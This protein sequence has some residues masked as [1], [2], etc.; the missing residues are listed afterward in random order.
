MKIPQVDLTRH[1]AEVH[2]EVIKAVDEIFRSQRFVL[3]ETVKNF[4]TAVAEYCQTKYAIGVASGTDALTLSLM[5]LGVK[6][7]EVIVPVFTFI[8]SASSIVLAGGKPVFADVDP[9]TFNIIP[10]E[11]EKRATKNTVGIIPVHLYGRPAEMNEITKIAKDKNLFVVE[12]MAQAI[13]AVYD[14][15]KVGGFGNT[16]ALSFYP[17]KNLGGAGDG[18]MVLTNNQNLFKKISRLRVHGSERRYYHDEIG[19]NSRLDAIQAVYLNIKL[20]HLEEWINDRIKTA[21]KYT[22]LFKQSGLEEKGVAFPKKVK[23]TDTWRNVFNQYTIKVPK[24]DELKNF[25]AEKG[26]GTEIYY[27]VPLHL[28]K[29]F[30]ELGH[31]IG[32]FPNAE[33]LSKE[34]LSLPMFPKIT[35]EEVE[36]VVES[37]VEFYKRQ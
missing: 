11:I 17:T 36:F 12:D 35:D 15:R 29:A 19:L 5:A 6:G 16:G 33:R 24:R 31:K 26:I 9:D 21:E 30:S 25:L 14:G 8:A 18:G 1:H 34:V 10:E 22:H 23:P 28:Q 13:G 3:G 7:K 4:E 32:D 20:K 2:E 27:P 37:I